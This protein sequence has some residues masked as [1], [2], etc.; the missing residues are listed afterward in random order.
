M[1]GKSYFHVSMFVMTSTPR[2]HACTAMHKDDREDPMFL[3]TRA[4]THSLIV[5][6][7]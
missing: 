7:E 2:W 6:R 3:S 4:Q 5:H 1:I